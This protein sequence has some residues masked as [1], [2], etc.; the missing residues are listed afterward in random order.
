MEWLRW[1]FARKTPRIPDPMWAAAIGRLPFLRWLAPSDLARLKNLSEA[2]LERKTFTGAGGFVLTDDIAVQ[3]AAQACLPVLNLTLD[4]YDDM[5]GVI[6]YPAAFIIP[7]AEVDEAGVV[8][9]WHEPVSGEA[10]DAGG[11]VVLSWEDVE[12]TDVAGYNVVIHE[13][14]HKL[15]MGSGSPNGFPPFLPEWHRSLSAAE[16]KREFSAAYQDFLRR[17]EMVDAALPADFDDENPAHASLYDT[18]SEQLPLDPY[19]AKH[20]AEFFAV[21]SEAFFV[22]PEPL[23][24]AYPAIYRLLKDYYR[25]DPHAAKSPDSDAGLRID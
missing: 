24:L 8:H 17:L 5:A 16:W 11:A 1:L 13:F 22:Y 25:Q 19:A 4:M 12:E 15:D 18:L 14:A 3:I 20:P 10:I 21:A 7:Q 2:L 9:E 6:V 23:A